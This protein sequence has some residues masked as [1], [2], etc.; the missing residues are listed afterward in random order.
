MS[1][2]V[3]LALALGL[4][5]MIGAGGAFAQTKTVSSDG[6]IRAAA[7]NDQFEIQSSKLAAEKSAD[8]AVK[9][10][11]AQMIADYGRSQASLSEAAQKA[12]M[13]VPATATPERDQQGMLAKLAK[14]SGKAFDRAFMDDQVA[15]Q[16]KI[17]ASVRQ[18]SAYG[19]NEDIRQVANNDMMMVEN[20]LALAE[21]LLKGSP[22]RSPN[23]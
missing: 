6:F 15:V 8:G 7:A 19:D 13:A 21:K 18:Y 1:R 10:F 22:G 17:L 3:K 16:K 2:Q 9:A 5:G 12:H 14:L 4:A 11:A 23:S 20:H